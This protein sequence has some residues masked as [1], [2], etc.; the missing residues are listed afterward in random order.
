MGTGGRLS[1]FPRRRRPDFCLR[2][3]DG[4]L[5]TFPRSCIT[6]VCMRRW[7][8]ST[9]MRSILGT[10]MGLP[11]RCGERGER[12]RPQHLPEHWEARFCAHRELWGRITLLSFIPL[13]PS[14]RPALISSRIDVRCGNV[15]PHT[16]ADHLLKSASRLFRQKHGKVLLG[17]HRDSG[18]QSSRPDV[19]SA[20]E[21]FIV[22]EL[23]RSVLEHHE[24]ARQIRVTA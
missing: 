7:V 9:V 8:T 17:S 13:P 10:T 3:C 6:T 19:A 15:Q 23:R 18:R 21:L 2:L 14:G 5:R 11:V 20:A 1:T 22:A 4:R 16:A 24:W 12:T